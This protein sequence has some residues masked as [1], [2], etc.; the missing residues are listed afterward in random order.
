MN[1]HRRGRS[2]AALAARALLLR[3][4][5][6]AFEH[7]SPKSA[8]YRSIVFASDQS[9]WSRAPRVQSA[10]ANGAATRASL[11]SLLERKWT[12]RARVCSAQAERLQNRELMTAAASRSGFES[13]LESGVRVRIRIR[14]C[15]DGRLASE[16]QMFRAVLHVYVC[17]GCALLI[18][19]S[20]GR[21]PRQRSPKM[22]SDF[23]RRLNGADLFSCVININNKTPDSGLAPA[24]RLW[25]LCLI[26]R[27][28]CARERPIEVRPIEMDPTGPM[29]CGL[30][31][32]TKIS[33][34]RRA[35]QAASSLPIQTAHS[36]CFADKTARPAD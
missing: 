15:A 27:E 16:R 6:G 4:S 31:F 22:S 36:H 2:R 12:G 7:L 3:R 18:V 25:R 11:A 23:G 34:I 8:I 9:E 10:A 30:I 35:S 19:R 28:Q 21:C 33:L 29:H 24:P 20:S 32:Q 14:I 1:K 13:E 26:A 17:V 5:C